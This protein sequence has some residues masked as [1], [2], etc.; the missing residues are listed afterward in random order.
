MLTYLLNMLS[1]LA[2]VIIDYIL[3]LGRRHGDMQNRQ[4]QANNHANPILFG[5]LIAQETLFVGLRD[6]HVG[7]DTIRYAEVFQYLEQYNRHWEPGF[8]LLMRIVHVFTSNP[9]V[10]V[11]IVAVL[12][13]VP[14]GFVLY[15]LSQYPYFSWL[16]YIGMYYFSF[17]FS[18]LRQCTAMAILFLAFYFLVKDKVLLP[19]LLILL[20]ASF[21]ISAFIFLP[22]LLLRKHVMKKWDFP[23]LILAYV[24]IFLFRGQIFNLITRFV[25]GEY[26]LIQTGAY[27]WA[28]VNI[29]LF[30]LLYFMS[31]FV[32]RD[33][34]VQLALSTMTIGEALML[35]TSVGT[36]M[37]RAAIYFCVFDTVA[38]PGVMR[39][40]PKRFRWLAFLAAVVI[41]FVFYWWHLRN[42][43]FTIIDYESTL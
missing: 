36:N 8:V 43:P 27:T 37:Q 38:L 20:A 42:N 19:L 24:L 31:F 11:F 12:S 25:Y 15:R 35:L 16:V 41:L 6:L 34:A 2:Y 29:A 30:F 7:V 23:I 5:I 39:A 9:H 28:L 13:I 10:F 18:G 32:K 26:E 17:T 14:V 40:V 22:V 4:K 21:H 33:R 3:R 1:V